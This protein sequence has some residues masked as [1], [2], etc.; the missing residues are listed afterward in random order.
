MATVS[1]SD[2]E[3]VEQTVWASVSAP[4]LVFARPVWESDVP[5]VSASEQPG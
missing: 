4:E 3:S 5:E 1:V 2:A